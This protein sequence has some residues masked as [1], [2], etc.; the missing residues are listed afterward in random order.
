MLAQTDRSG[1]SLGNIPKSYHELFR[2]L[3]GEMAVGT[4][5]HPMVGMR[6]CTVLLIATT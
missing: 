2:T 6:E 5:A 3:P 1:D 4:I